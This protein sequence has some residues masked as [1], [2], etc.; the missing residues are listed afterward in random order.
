MKATQI[1]YV[2]ENLSTRLRSERTVVSM[3][4]RLDGEVPVDLS[5]P[6]QPDVG[7][8]A[9]VGAGDRSSDEACIHI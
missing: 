4:K 8:I 3:D 7:K 1:L 2:P 9:N 6:S 5:A